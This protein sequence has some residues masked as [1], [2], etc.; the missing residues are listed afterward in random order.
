MSSSRARRSTGRWTPCP[1]CCTSLIAARPPSWSC[2][3]TRASRRKR[4]WRHWQ[5]TAPLA[6]RCWSS[7]NAG[8]SSK[9]PATRSSG[10]PGRSAPGMPSRQRGG[11]PPA[12]SS[13][14][15]IRGSSRWV[16]SSAQCS[17]RST[18]PPSLSPA[19]RACG[20][21]T[22][23]AISRRET[24]R[25]PRSGQAAMRSVGPTAS[26]AGPWTVAFSCPSA[27]P[28]GGDFAC[29]TK[30]PLPSRDAPSP[31]TCRCSCVEARL[32]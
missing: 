32:P 23:T 5:S 29:G 7:P 26:R 6:P 2:W 11:G 12:P 16:T 15:S 8:W 20:R 10:R 13:S 14:C 18:I 3:G 4:R 25:S 17:P 1:R 28:A 9:V 24:A 30:A 31:S 22:C 21:W 19:A 27:S